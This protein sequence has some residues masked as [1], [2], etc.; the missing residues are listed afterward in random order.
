MRSSS[1]YDVI[2]PIHL[3]SLLIGLTAF[4]IKRN[5]SPSYEIFLRCCTICWIALLSIWHICIIYVLVMSNTLWEY[6]DRSYMSEF[7]ER[8]FLVFTTVNSVLA[9][10]S[11]WWMF[12]M[13]SKFAKVLK[14]IHEIDEKL[15]TLGEKINTAKHVKV[16]II[17]LAALNAVNL[18]IVVALSIAVSMTQNYKTGIFGSINEFIGIEFIS[19]LPTQFAFFM[20]TVYHRFQKINKVLSSVHRG[21]FADEGQPNKELLESIPNLYDKLADI[22]GKLNFCYGFIVR[23]QEDSPNCQSIPGLPFQIMLL[24]GNSFL[25][26]IFLIY[27]ASKTL[28]QD[29][30]ETSWMLATMTEHLGILHLL[31]VIFGTAIMG[32]RV[33]SQ[34]CL[35]EILI[36]DLTFKGTFGKFIKD[37]EN[38]FACAQNSER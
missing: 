26:T 35:H 31:L 27:A 2:K 3:C 13:K 38:R 5:N 32:Q 36:L 15:E 11:I 8:C 21:M 24:I 20:W 17:F 16:V 37:K 14:E 28:I 4:S 33:K 6:V 12:A 22:V 18:S 25:C 10:F 29:Q 34:V 7:L 23:K 30:R 9:L 1:I 19:L